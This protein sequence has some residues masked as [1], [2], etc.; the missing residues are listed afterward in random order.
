MKSTLAYFF[1]L[2]ST[3]LLSA[4]AD[5]DSY[6]VLCNFSTTAYG[7]YPSGDLTLSPDGSTL[8]GM[9]ALGG[10]GGYGTIF[11]VSAS[12]GNPTKLFDFDQIHGMGTSGS[13]TLVGS[14]L[15]GATRG[16]TNYAG[17]IFS[18]PV[19]GGTPTNLYNFTGTSDNSPNC[20][21]TRI[22]SMIYGMTRYGGGV[23]N[24]GSIYSIPIGGSTP[25]TL[26]NFDPTQ[27]EGFGPLG[28]LTPS[29]DG[30]TFF[31]MTENGGTGHGTI[32]SIP[33]SGG[34]LKT[35]FNFDGAQHGELPRGNLTLSSDCLTLYGMTRNGG[36]NGAGVI[37][38]IPV[39]GGTPTTLFNFNTTSGYRPDGSLTLVGSTLYGL[40]NAGGENPYGTIFSIPTGGGTLTVLHSFDGLHGMNPYGSLT[41]SLDGS[42]LYGTTTSG[43]AFGSGGVAFAITVPEPST[44]A[45]LL[46]ASLGG[47]LWWRRRS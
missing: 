44:I 42:T 15:Y 10:T 29:S 46:T 11:K 7:N 22:G 14:T 37:F 35:L 1:A 38:S 26:H 8:Y 6:R 28:G 43:G 2:Y 9:T 18:I 41:A 40:T 27:V 30:S 20:N 45:L 31:G 17:V 34:P 36:T 12:G 21:L 16:G 47:L 3:V 24:S 4:P 33:V 13:L 23:R 25:T 19:T 39:S 32:F 5:A